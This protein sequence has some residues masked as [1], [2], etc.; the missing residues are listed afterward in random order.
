MHFHFAAGTPPGQGASWGHRQALRP[1]R[2]EKLYIKITSNQGLYKETSEPAEIA[3]LLGCVNHS[4]EWE[5]LWCG[6]ITDEELGGLAKLAERH[7]LEGY[8]SPDEVLSNY[9]LRRL[10]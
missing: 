2:T 5:H 9:G 4:K 10:A 8:S 1:K 7:R 3:R 6:T